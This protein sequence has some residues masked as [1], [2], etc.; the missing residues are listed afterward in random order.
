LEPGFA[1]FQTQ[2]KPAK[3]RV[4]F[5]TTPKWWNNTLHPACGPLLPLK[6]EKGNR[7]VPASGAAKCGKAAQKAGFYF[8]TNSC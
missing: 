8:L 5:L 6:R 3:N 2:D 1:W 7:A 4:Y